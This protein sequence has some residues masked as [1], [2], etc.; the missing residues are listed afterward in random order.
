MRKLTMTLF[1]AAALALPTAAFAHNGH[2]GH[3]HNF[4]HHHGAALFMNFSQ[5]HGAALFT[6]LS[7][8]GT[9]FALSSSTAS[10]TFA[11]DPLATG[12]FAANLSSDWTKSETKT[13]D[14]G[15]LVCAPATATVTLTDGAS[16][17]N[18]AAGTLTGKTCDF[19]KADGTIFRGFFG[20]GSVTGTG[21]LAGLT[22]TERAFM[23][24]QADGTVK[25]AV[26][27]GSNDPRSMD[28]AKN[29]DN[30]KRANNLES[31]R[32]TGQQNAAALKTGNC[33]HNK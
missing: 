21:T 32:F 10:G 13:T 12:T 19:T 14:H 29:M 11:G 15:T 9:S 30:T 20:H 1:A 31:L 4:G 26:F 5:H 6:K 33:D 22:G 28:N 7:G 25:G 16:S 18:T 17:A 27:A 2:G 8:T 3:H 24:Q 23:S